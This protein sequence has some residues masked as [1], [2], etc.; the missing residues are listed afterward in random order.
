MTPSAFEYHRAESLEHAVTLL[1]EFG[2]E[3][4]PLAGGQS[5]VPMMN[6]RLARPRYLVDINGLGLSSIELDGRMLKIGA[7]VRHE[8]YLS[9][10]LVAAHFPAFLDGVRAIGHPTIRRNGTTGGSLSHAD[11]TAELPLLSILHDALIVAV[12]V[13]GERRIAAIDF[14]EG[15]YMTAL[16]PGEMIVRVEIP[17][18]PS[19]SAGAFVEF[20]ERRG[21]FAI[22]AGAVALEF[23]AGRIARAAIACSGVAQAAIRAPDLEAALVGRPIAQPES[24]DDVKVFAASLSPPDDHSASADYRRAL[25]EELLQRAISIACARATEAS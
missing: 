13:R 9:D 25:I 1:E 14:F 10:G 11:P 16:E 18:P 15:A 20:G 23:D 17:I 5:I 12:S 6:L 22:A 4:R 24:K 19:R 3:G 21:D 8:Q 2:D 7:L